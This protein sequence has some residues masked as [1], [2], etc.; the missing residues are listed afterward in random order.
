V[1]KEHTQTRM[2]ISWKSLSAKLAHAAK[3]KHGKVQ[4]IKHIITCVANNLM[5]CNS[6]WRLESRIKATEIPGYF[7]VK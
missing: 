4:K 2:A 1:R 7:S 5:C 6:E 3:N